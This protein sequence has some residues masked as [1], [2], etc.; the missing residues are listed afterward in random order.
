[1]S[2]DLTLITAR[3]DRGAVNETALVDILEQD[4]DFSENEEYYRPDTL[5]LGFK[6]EAERVSK[7]I[8]EKFKDNEEESERLDSMVTELFEIRGFIGASSNYGYYRY[9][10][11]ETDF[12]Y[13]VVIAATFN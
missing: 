2:Q 10:V 11:I 7:E 4:N 6:N 12:E 3:I 9:D 1:M 5:A 13:I 8:Y